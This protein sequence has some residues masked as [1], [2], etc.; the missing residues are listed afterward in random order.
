VGYI[1]G[2]ERSDN[3]QRDPKELYR[4]LAALGIKV[5][6]NLVFANDDLFW[7][8]WKYRAEEHVTSLRH[9]NE[10]IGANITAGAIIHVYLYLDQLRENAMYCDTDYV[11]YIKPRDEPQMIETGTNWGI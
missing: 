8:W 2:A 9:T 6:W 10:V 3:N 7:I 11:I 5:K 4:F 1:D